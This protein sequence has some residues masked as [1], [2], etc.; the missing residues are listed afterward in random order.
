MKNKKILTLV[1][2]IFIVV[3]CISMF[4]GCTKKHENMLNTTD[5]IFKYETLKDLSTEWILSTAESTEQSDVFT[6]NT[7]NDDY[8]IT[9]DTKSA[10]WAYVAQKVYLNAGNY[11]RISYNVDINEIKAL[12]TGNN[13]DGVFVT[14]IEDEDFNYNTERAVSQIEAVENGNYIVTFKAKES[15][16]ATIAFKIGT[17][18]AP[19]SAIVTLNSLKLDRI[20]K[21][22]AKDN[23]QGEFATDH[24]GTQSDFN[25]F[26][27]VIGGVLI[28]V[29]CYIGYFVFQ[30]QLHKNEVGYDGFS[31]KVNDSK[32]IGLLLV[33]GIGLIIRLVTDAL[34][35]IIASG[36]IYSNMGYNLEGLTTQAMFIAKYGPQNLEKSLSAFAT[37]NGYTYLAPSSSPLQLYFLGFC[38]L[39]GRI[40]ET[41]PGGAFHGTLFFIRFFCGL[42]D[43]GTALI[44]YALIKNSIGKTAATVMASL[45]VTLPVV[46]ATSSL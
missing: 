28:A 36:Y 21:N 37:G 43:I 41:M 26:Y 34:S 31:A 42:A 11:Y 22:E 33:V 25:I 24:Y 40:F 7:K 6:M 29:L 23:Y 4:S 20:T 1:S 16:Y 46:F 13:F 3:L 17:E 12:S 44:I 14:F 32:V 39:F 9:I 30:R 15:G 18:K 8:S 19:A 10:G 38:G 27:I 35:T 45:Y 2:V 5:G